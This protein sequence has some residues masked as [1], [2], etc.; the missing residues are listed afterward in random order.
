MSGPSH[1][2]N[3]E[4]VTVGL[5]EWPIVCDLLA[6]GRCC[7]LLRK[8]GVEE[9]DGPG[10]FRLEHDRFAL[11]PAW[12]HQK[13][14]W[15]KAEF[16]DHTGPAMRQGHE[17]NPGNAPQLDSVPLLAIA[18]PARVWRLPLRGDGHA[19]RE[20][21]DALDDLHPWRRPQIDMRFDYKPDR[22][23]YLVALRVRRLAEAK[24]KVV[25]L[26]DAYAGCR[27][28][29]PLA[30]EDTIDA[31]AVAGAVPAMPASDLA[32]VLDR[33]DAALA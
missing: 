6:A 27:S 10:R 30:D 31:D 9:T 23:L 13:L 15:V 7:L 20:R 3:D 18:E 25:P 32:A 12:E 5:K 2:V 1:G 16:E 24:T 11:F 33:I 8:G 4:A 29:V 19:D 21:F 22:P 28:W 26:R 14:E 17:A